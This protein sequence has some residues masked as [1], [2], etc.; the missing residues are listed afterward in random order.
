MKQ[1]TILIAVFCLFWKFTVSQDTSRYYPKDTQILLKEYGKFYR[2]LDKKTPQKFLINDKRLLEIFEKAETFD[3]C[4]FKTDYQ[5]VYEKYKLL[6]AKEDSLVANYYY[7]LAKY[8]KVSSGF[9][10]TGWEKFCIK[11]LK[12]GKTKKRKAMEAAEKLNKFYRDELTPSLKKVLICFRQFW[13]KEKYRCDGL[14]I[15]WKETA[16]Y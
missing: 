9:K 7:W 5:P 12:K 6:V 4:H 8:Q 3:S 15:D 10:P 14:G 13:S 1:T 11:T 2:N 16:Y